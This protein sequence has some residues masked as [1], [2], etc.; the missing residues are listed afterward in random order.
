VQLVRING[1][2]AEIVPT[3]SVPVA[4]N[5]SCSPATRGC[6]GLRKPR[7]SAGWTYRPAIDRE[8]C[9]LSITVR[10]GGLPSARALR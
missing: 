8:V 7:L 1:E 6:V 3:V 5:S 9:S 10:V 4:P 2:L